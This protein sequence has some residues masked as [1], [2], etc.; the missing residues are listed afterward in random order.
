MSAIMPGAEPFFF[1][2]GEVGVLLVHG[3]TASPQEVHELGSFL[4]ERGS[5]VLGVRLAG[6]GTSLDNLARTHWQDWLHS[7][8]DG[9]AL[10]QDR[11]KSIIL[12]GF[13]TGGVLSLLLSTTYPAAGI[14][15]M[16]TPNALPPIPLLK[17][18]YPLLSFL[19][20]L[21]PNIPKGPPDWYE[22]QANEKRVAYDRY[23]PESIYQFGQLVA[24]LQDNLPRVN[25]PILMMHS[26]NDG[27]IPI[28]QMY[29]IF[30]AV[31]SSR[32]ETFTVDRS[33]H[34]ITCDAERER[35]FERAAQFIQSL[36][37]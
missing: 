23:P 24:Q 10:L 33:N 6:H 30:E 19:G 9:Y 17:I 15:T 36:D 1:Q 22:P 5:T 4:S 28:E 2:R 35:V 32:K 3:F 26:K 20:P 37:L 29:Q 21:L 13:S 12:G 8:E 16:S 25:A 18:I 14:I 27:F 34:I 11:C 31:G 7:V